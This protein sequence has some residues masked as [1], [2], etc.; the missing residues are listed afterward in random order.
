MITSSLLS[1]ARA[2]SVRPRSGA[3]PDHRAFLVRP[4]APDIVEGVAVETYRPCPRCLA[5]AGDDRRTVTVY[6][7]RD[8][9]PWW[10]TVEIHCCTKHSE[11]HVRGQQGWIRP[12]THLAGQLLPI[13]TMLGAD[14]GRPRLAVLAGEQTATRLR[15][16]ACERPYGRCAFDLTHAAPPWLGHLELHH[17][18]GCGAASFWSAGAGG[19]VAPIEHTTGADGAVG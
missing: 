5:P 19:P 16:E 14:R 12:V 7:V 13:F 8:R 18:T 17:C 9:V 1:P 2:L 4:D 6:R 15:C 10:L 3:G 11:L